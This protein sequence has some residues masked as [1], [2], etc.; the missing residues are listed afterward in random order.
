MTVM[1]RQERREAPP[2]PAGR[3]GPVVEAISHS[4]SAIEDIDLHTMW[5]T[6]WR[7]RGLVAVATLV[8]CIVAVV[9][10]QSLTPVYTASTQVAIG[11]R[12]NQ[13]VNLPEVLATLK[14][15]PDTIPTEMG[16]IRSR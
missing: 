15:D 6:I 1:E 13:A 5:R 2:M 10:V 16:V 4:R 7:W 3:R 8:T 12:Q 11:L 9:T 14:G